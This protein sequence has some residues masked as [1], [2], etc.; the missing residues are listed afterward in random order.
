MAERTSLMCACMGNPADRYIL[1]FRGQWIGTAALG[2]ALFF[3]ELGMRTTRYRRVSE[4]RPRHASSKCP[5]VRLHQVGVSRMSNRQ[6]R[7][8]PRSTGIVATQGRAPAGLLRVRYG[9]MSA[10][11]RHSEKY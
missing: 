11:E 6:S 10:P 7:Y 3:G 9:S 5:Q 4:L 8:R 1:V 2:S